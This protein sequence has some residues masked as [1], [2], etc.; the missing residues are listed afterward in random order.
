MDKNFAHK[1]LLQAVDYLKDNG[2]ARTHEEIAQLTGIRRPFISAAIRGDFSRITQGNLSKFADAYSE[3]INKE[4]LIDGIGNMEVPRGDKRK[5]IPIQVAAGFQGM[6]LNSVRDF[7][8]EFVSLD[9]LYGQNCNCVVRAK[10]DSMFPTIF[11]GDYI[12][13]QKIDTS[14]EINPNDIYIVDSKEGAVI[15]RLKLDGDNLIA[16]SDNPRYESFT[17]PMESVISIFK[18]GG[19]LRRF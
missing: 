7:E 19:I 10:G 9:E 8:C 13:C 18:V 11:D 15:K 5:Y 4:W 1:R 3:Y 6:S 14:L 16:K 12:M 2:K 17:I